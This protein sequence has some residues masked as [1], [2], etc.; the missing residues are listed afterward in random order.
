MQRLSRR[1]IRNGSEESALT[2]QIDLTQPDDVKFMRAVLPHS[3]GRSDQPWNWYNVLGDVVHQGVARGARIAGYAKLGVYELRPD[4]QIGKEITTGIEGRVSD[5]LQSPYGGQRA[6]MERFFTL[7]K[8]PGDAY[9]VRCREGENVIGYDVLA[10]R[11]IDLLNTEGPA[12]RRKKDEVFAPGQEILRVTHPK[13]GSTGERLVVKFRAEDFIGRI[14]RP[15]AE[16]VDVADSPMHA[17]QDTCEQL[18]LLT[19]SL[20]AKLLGRLAM[21]GILFV[22]S[23][24][25]EIKSGAPD[26]KPNKVTGNDVIDKLIK[27]ATWSVMNPGDP[28]SALPIFMSGPGEL[29]DM[30]KFIQSDT[31]FFK[32]DIELREE[33][34]NRILM[35]LDVMPEGVKGNSEQNHWNSWSSVDDD[36]R[37]NVRPEVETFCWAATRC[38]L[39]AEMQ[40]AGL[41]PGRIRKRVV[42][43][44]LSAA[45]AR[46]NMAEDARQGYDRNI[47]GPTGARRMTGIPEAEAPTDIETIRAYGFKNGD[48]YAATYGMAEQKNIDWDKVGKTK[49]GPSPDS[50]ADP[51]E[52]GPGKSAGGPDDSKSDT[53]RKDRPA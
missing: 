4:G 33:L 51:S 36:Q 15:T 52:S 46:T 53:P 32:L 26:G 7:S 12:N 40:A 21:N 22:P 37:I 17:L 31:E 30:I 48:L 18:W 6:L 3:Q 41:P 24:I 10:A 1:V 11:E 44:D 39:H 38:I 49:T 19:R 13:I 43:Y 47:V 28:G 5:L 34:I 2:A 45:S 9:L 29:G 16:Y 27:A 25:N 42:W 8:V 23:G 14:W 50:T 20:R 35:G